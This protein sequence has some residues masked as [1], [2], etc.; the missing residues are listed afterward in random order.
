MVHTLVDI[1]LR[2]VGQCIGILSQVRRFLPWKDK[3][4][5]IERMCSH[6]LFTPTL[7][8]SV[9]YHLF[10]PELK[11]VCLEWNDQVID[12]VLVQLSKCGCQLR[13]LKIDGCKKIT[14][15]TVTSKVSDFLFNS[16]NRRRHLRSV[17]KPIRT[18]SSRVEKPRFRPENDRVERTP[19]GKSRLRRVEIA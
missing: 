17:E 8:P 3:E 12:G 5:L 11:S 1:C 15:K 14:G 18:R 19:R 2:S 13:Y 7:L 6:R 9:T 10:A 16:S 4:R